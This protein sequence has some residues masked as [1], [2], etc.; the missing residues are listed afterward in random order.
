MSRARLGSRA[1]FAHRGGGLTQLPFLLLLAGY[2]VQAAAGPFDDPPPASLP[3]SG[4]YD[5]GAS[6]TRNVD[7]LDGLPVPEVL[8][9]LLRDGI[10]YDFD[11]HQSLELDLFGHVPDGPGGLGQVFLLWRIALD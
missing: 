9:A 8:K 3:P 11:R 2:T 6:R 7:S 10:R 1:V 4:A 5:R